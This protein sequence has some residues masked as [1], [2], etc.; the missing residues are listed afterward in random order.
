MN[1]LKQGHKLFY[2]INQFSLA[3][4]QSYLVECFVI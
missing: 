1:M 4:T 3:D 2:G